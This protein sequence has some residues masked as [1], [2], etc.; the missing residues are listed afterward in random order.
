M[1]IRDVNIP[2][3]TYLD[4]DEYNI[5]QNFM[6]EKLNKDTG[7]FKGF[8]IIAI[9]SGGIVL[10]VVGK[11]FKST[12]WLTG[13]SVELAATVI[14]HLDG[15]IEIMSRRFAMIQERKRIQEI[16][17][18]QSLDQRDFSEIKSGRWKLLVTVGFHAI[19]KGIAKFMGEESSLLNLSK[20][21]Q[22]LFTG[23]NKNYLGIMEKIKS[24]FI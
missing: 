8:I 3:P 19:N 24:V 21:V 4:T 16:N 5:P 13:G 1:E 11:T 22:K 20:M 10:Q 2:S 18:T 15:E 9:L 14:T 12:D 23:E 7:R 6:N 17:K